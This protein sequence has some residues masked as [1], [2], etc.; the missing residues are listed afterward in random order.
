M[1]ELS[2]CRTVLD[3][4]ND[5]VSGTDYKQV[6][7]ITLDIGQLAAVD[8]AALRF[9]FDVVTKG[10]LAEHALLEIIEI[11]GMA[12]CDFCQKT[13]KLKRY[14]DACPS[15]GHFSLTVTQGEELRVKCMEVE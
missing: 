2:L 5:H 14:D 6:K 13:V 7:K 12:F 1:H 11:E 15:C 4:I 3:I 9:S 10:T 8:Q